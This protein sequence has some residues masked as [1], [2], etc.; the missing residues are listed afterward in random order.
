MRIQI[1]LALGIALIAGLMAAAPVAAQPGGE[2]G[3]LA[4]V[5]ELTLARLVTSPDSSPVSYGG[6]ET[7]VGEVRAVLAEQARSLAAALQPIIE[8]RTLLLTQQRAR[9]RAETRR[10]EAALELL[11]QGRPLVP[12]LSGERLDRLRREAIE[13]QQRAQSIEERAREILR[14]LGPSQD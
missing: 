13:L 1:A 9:I 3:G 8:R 4:G 12:E 14:Q 6:R 10:I 2:G 11:R 5:E 7:T